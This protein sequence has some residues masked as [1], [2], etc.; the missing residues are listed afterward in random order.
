M[1]LT[2]NLQSLS[3]VL[4]SILDPEIVDLINMIQSKPG[5]S[6]S[7]FISLPD[8]REDLSVD[9]IRRL[10]ATSSNKYSHACRLA[11]LARA[12]HKL[13]KAAYK[14]KYEA[15][16]GPGKNAE[17]REANANLKAQ[18]ELD[19]VTLLETIVELCES[20]ENAARVASESS[21]RM[22][23]GADQYAK[24]EYRVEQNADALVREDF[25]TF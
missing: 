21:R 5:N 16:L 10:V 20:I 8:G 19:K 7:P 14:R 3:T 9:N 18:E 25:E 23:L 22:L 17:E 1:S 12:Q 24:A 4:E 11:G 13:A 6:G 2:Y 15:S